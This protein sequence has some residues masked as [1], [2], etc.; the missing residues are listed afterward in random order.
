VT[1][2]DFVILV[3]I[4]PGIEQLLHVLHGEGK[5][6]IQDWWIWNSAHAGRLL[7]WYHYEILESKNI[8]QMEDS[9]RDLHELVA[10]AA[11]YWPLLKGEELYRFMARRVRNVLS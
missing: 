6:V 11:R 7:P 5:L 4:L 9:A 3:S 1:S 2:A 8:Y 10:C